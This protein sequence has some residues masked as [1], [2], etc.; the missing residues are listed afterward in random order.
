MIICKTPLR[1]SLF[2]GG[3]DFPIWFK[4]NKGMTISFTINKYCYLSLRTLPNLFPF[5]YRLRY[6]VNETSNSLDRIKHPSIKAVLKKYHKSRDGLEIVH[7]SD[8]PGLSGLGSSSAFT[9]S[10]L[11]LIHRYNGIEIKKKELVK[12]C[13]DIEHNI[14]K[15]ASGFQDQY[16]CVYGGLNLI[17]YDKKKINIRNLKI[18]KKNLNHLISNSILVYSGIQRKSELIERDKIKNIKKNNKRLD[19]ILEITGKA[20]KILESN[21]NYNIRSVAYL[22][23]ES[24]K[25]K[26]ELSKFVSNSKIDQLYDFGLKNGAIGG[27]LLGAGGGGYVLFLTENKQKQKKLIKRLKKNVYFKFSVDQE[28]SKIL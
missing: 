3:T 11:N 4:K 14:L 17:H 22:L 8:I 20:K 28:G 26:R 1:I 23:N 27:K 10:M 2:G 13:I 12:K 5:K 21:S 18:K 16:A 15:E 7:S 25:F 6:F 24:W 19:K 9:I